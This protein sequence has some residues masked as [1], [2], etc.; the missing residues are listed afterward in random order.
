MGRGS[1]FICSLFS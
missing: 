1:K